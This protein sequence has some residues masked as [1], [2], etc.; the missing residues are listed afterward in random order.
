MPV[1]T[2][3]AFGH[4]ANCKLARLVWT[5][6]NHAR[7]SASVRKKLRKIFAHRLKGPFD[8][9]VA[10][11]NWR[12]YPEQNYCD[13]VIFSRNHMPEQKEHKALDKIIKADMCFV[14]IGSNVGTYSLYLAIKSPQA[15]ILALEPQPETFQKLLFNLKA[16]AVD[17]VTALQLGCGPTRHTM[18]LWSGGSNTGNTSLLEKGTANP[19]KAFEVPVVPLLELLDEHHFQRIDLLKIDIEGYEDQA[20]APFFLNAKKALWPRYVLIETAHQEFWQQNIIDLML[21][22][23]YHAVF[24]TDENVILKHESNPKL[25]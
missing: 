13:R 9:N 4:Y 24:N 8:V 3:S 22:E 16:N 1:D 14:D 12:L 25:K 19:E 6:C 17:N 20:L 7:L 10:G 11:I 15:R 23:D 21:A 2:S 18:K 5:I